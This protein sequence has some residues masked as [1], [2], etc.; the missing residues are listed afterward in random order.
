MI[1]SIAWLA[2]VGMQSAKTQMARFSK[3][4]GRFHRFRVADFTDENHIRSLAQGV[5]QRGLEGLSVK[6]DFP[7]GDNRLFVPMHEFDWIFDGNNVPRFRQVP[8]IDHGRQ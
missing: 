4:N 5:F 7:L 1:R 6:A 3:G 2:I 8:M